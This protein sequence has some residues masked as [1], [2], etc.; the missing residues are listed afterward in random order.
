MSQKKVDEDV[1]PQYAK[2]VEAILAGKPTPP[3]GKRPGVKG[4]SSSR[5]IGSIK[6]LFK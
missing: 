2:R 5:L 3:P 1:G 4:K 6:G